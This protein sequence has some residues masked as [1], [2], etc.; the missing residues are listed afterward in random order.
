VSRVG[1]NDNFFELGGHSLLAVS[2]ISRVRDALG[3]Q[4]KVR[5]L[6]EAPTVARLARTLAEL[7]GNASIPPI[8]RVER[9]GHLPLSFA[10]ERLWFL[11]QLEESAFYNMPAA[12]RVSG[13]LNVEHLRRA[14][15]ALT[16]RHEVLRTTFAVVEEKPVQVISPTPAVTFTVCDLRGLER[17][18]REAE[19]RRLTTEEVQRPF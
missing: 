10:Q 19:I 1:V 7:H 6:F 12:F 13:A 11:D 4:L 8:T 5:S 17:E 14:F 2:M 3:V 9:E 16:L 15:D 18:A